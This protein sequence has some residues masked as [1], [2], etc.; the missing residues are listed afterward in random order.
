MKFMRER[1]FE[2]L[3]THVWIEIKENGGIGFDFEHKAV[4]A[5]F[6]DRIDLRGDVR[7]FGEIS[8]RQARRA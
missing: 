8:Q 6:D 5:R 7:R 1:V 4:F 3:S 2:F